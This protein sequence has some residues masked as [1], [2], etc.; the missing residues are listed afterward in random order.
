MKFKLL[1]ITF[2]TL[3]L[4]GQ[5]VPDTLYRASRLSPED[6]KRIGKES[7]SGVDLTRPT[8]VP[9]Y[10][11]YNHAFRS[12]A[13]G[14]TPNTVWL[15]STDSYSIAHQFVTGL[16]SGAFSGNGWIYYI[17]PTPNFHSVNEILGTY[18]PRPV[19]RE[20]ACMGSLYFRQIMGWREVTFGVP[21]PYVR[22]RHFDNTINSRGGA[23]EEPA[24]ELALFPSGHRAW[25][26]EPWRSYATCG[27]SS[28]SFR[29]SLPSNNCSATRTNAILKKY[30]Y[31]KSRK[32]IFRNLNYEDLSVQLC[33]ENAVDVYF[34]NFKKGNELIF[35]YDTK[36]KSYY[37]K[38]YKVQSIDLDEGRPPHGSFDEHD[39]LDFSWSANNTITYKPKNLFGAEVLIDNYKD[40][41]VSQY[42]EV[43]DFDGINGGS[44][45]AIISSYSV[46]N[47]QFIEVKKWGTRSFDPGKLRKVVFKNVSYDNIGQRRIRLGDNAWDL[48]PSIN[49]G[50]GITFD[51]KGDGKVSYQGSV[52]QQIDMYSTAPLAYQS[53]DELDFSWYNSHEINYRPY[54]CDSNI[55][56][57]TLVDFKNGFYSSFVDSDGI[58]GKSSQMYM[59]V[60]LSPDGK[61][62]NIELHGRADS[63]SRKRISSP[64]IIE[65]DDFDALGEFEVF[66][67]PSGACVN[68]KLDDSVEAEDYCIYDINGVLLKRASI[69][70]KSRLA[71]IDV[72]FLSN[73]IYFLSVNDKNGIGKTKKIQIKK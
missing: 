25:Q 6:F 57:I 2:F 33:L 38:G 15:G 65:H 13:G 68:L 55:I 47:V 41:S 8:D 49:K 28:S 7:P 23:C 29:S 63:K 3:T 22:N 50:Y 19:E 60:N 71:K 66:P 12:E 46:S 26:V 64:R 40:L 14:S 24:Y 67:N 18:S 21:G 20:W 36:S 62:L 56:N 39:N 32:L 43:R 5:N 48:W 9:D 17:R 34:Y 44:K 45:N 73:G 1:I 61:T 54:W 59:K 16:H 4:F 35:N 58:Q 72:S 52:V 51:Y 30:F 37:Y 53:G 69:K 31:D 10:S 70:G 11:L 42:R 27:A